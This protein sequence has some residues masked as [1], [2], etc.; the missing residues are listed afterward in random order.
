MIAYPTETVWGLGCDPYNKKAV[1]RIRKLKKRPDNKG[2]ITIV[3]NVLRLRSL[4]GPLSMYTQRCIE[5]Y[6]DRPTTFVIS[7]SK[8]RFSFM[9]DDTIAV[10]ISTDIFSK[11]LIGLA[12][13]PIV[14]TSAN[15]SGEPPATSV[16]EINSAI[17]GGVDYVVPEAC[18]SVLTGL[19]S[20]IVRIHSVDNRTEILRM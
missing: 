7:T 4:I 13:I 12:D 1:S 9:Y 17:L 2:F 19:P 14:S 10:R 18:A 15:L 16:K 11:Q 6:S 5:E 20:R 3:D 8:V